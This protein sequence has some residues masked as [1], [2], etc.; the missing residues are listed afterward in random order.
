[1]ARTAT[2]FL[3]LGGDPVN[4]GEVISSSPLVIARSPDESGRRSKLDEIP[5]SLSE[6]APQ[7]R[8]SKVT[9]VA[10]SVIISMG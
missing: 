8:I 9:L 1:V 2:Y 3:S 7:T 4:R 10:G 5:R 6:Q